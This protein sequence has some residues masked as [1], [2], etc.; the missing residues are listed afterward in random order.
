MTD[1]TCSECGSTSWRQLLEKDYPERRQERDR[2]IERVYLCAEC[3]A[4][5]KHFIHQDGGLP[6]F[7]G[8]M[9]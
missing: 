5:G 4:Q 8:A 6:T 9:R 7:S 1:V 3:D 2:T